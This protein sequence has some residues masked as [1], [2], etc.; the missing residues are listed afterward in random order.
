MGR[1]AV[2]VP[3][4]TA[5][6]DHQTLNALEFA[7]AGA[8]VVVPQYTTAANELADI[9]AALLAD[10]VRLA[11][12]GEAMRKLGRPHA[13]RQIV[14]ELGALVEGKVRRREAG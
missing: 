6:D 12:M 14:D 10:P 1:P 9:V 8:A 5:A 7:R 4:P 2:L 11:Q 13:T 3:L